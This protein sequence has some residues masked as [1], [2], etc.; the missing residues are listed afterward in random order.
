MTIGIENIKRDVL[1]PEQRRQLV[2]SVI[3][4]KGHRTG[5][6]G[7]RFLVLFV[8]NFTHSYPYKTATWVVLGCFFFKN[9][10]KDLPSIVTF[11]TVLRLTRARYA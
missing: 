11:I 4:S 5:A 1:L 8:E 3:R 9:I 6:A 7:G 2:L 10:I